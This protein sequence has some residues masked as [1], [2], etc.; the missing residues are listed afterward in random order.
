MSLKVVTTDTK[1]TTATWSDMSASNLEGEPVAL[2]KHPNKSVQII[3]DLDSA[4]FALQG[5]MDGTNWATLT[6]DGTNGITGLGLFT[7]HENPTY[8]RPLLTVPG[9]ETPV[10]TVILGMSA[11][12]Q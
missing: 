10:I 1:Y 9:V 6:R 5:S 3:G 12:V 7:V 4:T 8:I 2:G 11:L